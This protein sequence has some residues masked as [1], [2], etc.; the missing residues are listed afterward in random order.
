MND[1]YVTFRSVT[2]AMS[3]SRALE[4]AGIHAE[5]FRTPK[6]LQ[7]QGCGYSLRIRE[8]SFRMARQHLAQQNIRYNKIYRRAGR[9]DWREVSNDLF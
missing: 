1:Y 2:A 8:A 4:R 6:S 9:G 7:Q 3:G 5:L